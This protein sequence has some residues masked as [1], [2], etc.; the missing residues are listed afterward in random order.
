[1]SGYVFD[2]GMNIENF[3]KSI[4][5]VEDELKRL[6]DSLKTA[7]GQG[8]VE[9]NVQIKQLE[10]SLVDLKKV[11]LDKLPGGITNASNALNSLSQ[12]TRDL[13]FGFVAIQNNLPL[14]VDSFGQL[15]RQAGGLG[16]A[17]KSIGA[18]L[19]GP[20][21]LSFAFGAIIA[22]V[23]ALIQKYGSLSEALTQILGGTKK[24]TAEQKLF[25]EETAK[26]TGNVAAEEAKVK[27]LTKTL[28]DNDKPQKDRLAAY[29]ELKKIAPEVVAGIREE[30]I[31]TQISNELIDS[32]AKKRIELI[33][34]KIRETGINAVLA[35]NSQD[36]AVEQDKLNQL[37]DERRLLLEKQKKGDKYVDPETGKVFDVLSAVI[38][39]NELRL[40]AQRVAVENLY[41]INGNFLTQL[42]PIVNGIAKINEETRIRIENLKKEDQALKDSAKDGQQKYKEGWQ[43]IISELKAIAASWARSFLAAGIATY[44]AVGW[45]ANAIVN[46]A[47]AASLPVIL[48]YL[49]PND[50]A[51]GRR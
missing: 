24:I 51:F 41:K 1:M 12:V 8:I 9:T 20:A 16:P 11:G 39:E 38:R 47:L 44:L 36:I 49:N 2:L 33:K 15:T 3:T 48:R 46:A 13:P 43:G 5:E 29:S 25:N 22:G 34:L 32:N 14:V 7:T 17:L 30:N 6:K 23:T 50:S 31:G 40:V 42:D 21:G 26:A 18:S 19:I 27:I 28:I 35:K 37:I 45:D 4:S 10:K